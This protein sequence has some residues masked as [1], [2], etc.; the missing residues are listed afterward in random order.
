MKRSPNQILVGILAPLK[1]HRID[2]GT[3]EMNATKITILAVMAMLLSCTLLSSAGDD[4]AIPTQNGRLDPAAA[5]ERAR[6]GEPDELFRMTQMMAQQPQLLPSRKSLP[7][8]HKYLQDENVF[9]QYLA[10]QVVAGLKDKSSAEPLRQFIMDTERGR[11][12]LDALGEKNLDALGQ[13]REFALAFASRTALAALGEIDEGSPI[14]VKV[15]ASQL[16]H[17]RPME[18]GGGVAHSALAKKGRAGLRALLDEAAQPLD[19]KQVR[20]LGSAMNEI[21]D[22]AL[23]VD[24]YACC[25][26]QKYHTVA[27]SSALWVLGKMAKQSPDV[28]Q[29]VISIAEDDKSDLRSMA[30]GRLGYIGSSLSRKKLLE[31]EK[32]L[33]QEANAVQAAL[34]MCDTTNRLPGV[35]EAFLSPKTPLAEKKRLWCLLAGRAAELLPY[36]EQLLVVSDE[37][38]VPINDLR[39]SVWEMLF[40]LTKKRYPIELDASNEQV[41]QR[42]VQDITYSFEH[43][44]DHQDAGKWKYTDLQRKQ[45]AS[46]EAKKLIKKWDGQEKKESQQGTAPLPRAP[47]GRSEGAR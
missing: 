8:Y 31:F 13:K 32:A 38:G 35:I 4:Q 25:K 27:R 24:L 46:E 11:K 15:L 14:N 45:M 21:S 44:L 33:P 34:L 26:D 6:Q 12:D 37:N 28:E 9:V 16:M 42:V 40:S 23:A 10:V 18:W 41:F 29:M 22:P 20:F 7:Q 1:T 3:A 39:V 17:D 30:I 36:A 5:I 19:D 43:E 2:V 47:A